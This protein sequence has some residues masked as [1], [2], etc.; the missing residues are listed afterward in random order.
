M[1][2]RGSKHIPAG[3]DTSTIAV[4]NFY[5]RGTIEFPG[6]APGNPQGLCCESTSVAS[7]LW[8]CCDITT[9]TLVKAKDLPY[10][11]IGKRK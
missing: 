5:L 4:G 2:P 1:N 3:G 7:V 9:V 6:I 11:N 10:G 8:L